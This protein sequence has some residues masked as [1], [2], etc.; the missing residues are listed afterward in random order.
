MAFRAVTVWHAKKKSF[1]PQRADKL[2]HDEFFPTSQDIPQGP[3]KQ[4]SF[5]TGGHEG[6]VQRVNARLNARSSKTHL[7]KKRQ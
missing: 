6:P 3:K 2:N 1:I 4:V 5:S 7:G